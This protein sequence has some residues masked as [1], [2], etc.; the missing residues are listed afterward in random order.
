M[1][2]KKI[3]LPHGQTVLMLIFGLI[4]MFNNTLGQDFTTCSEIGVYGGG[5]Y[6][7]GDLNP[8]RHFVDS[9]PGFGL[10]YRYNVSTRHSV[11]ATAFYGNL[12]ADDADASDAFQQNRNLSFKSSILEL[13]IG[14]EIDLFK[15]RI[16][17]MKYPISPY[18]F[19]QFAVARINPTTEFEGN[20]V[21]L[22]PLGT[23]GQG[24]SENEKNVYSLNQ[25]TIPL[26]IGL[27][28]NLR[29][30]VAISVEY[31]IRKTF[32]DYIDDVSGSYANADIL[33]A[34]NGPL[35]ATLA[36]RSLNGETTINRGNP[37][38]K[39]WYTFYGVMLTI[40]PFEKGICERMPGR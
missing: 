30:R 20:D 2:G 31:G 14:Y 5:S 4:G 13:A 33:R 18:F 38:T 7:I 22:R 6:Y 24:T 40:K 16:N 26:G 25:I 39:D 17:D 8:N 27:K 29:K 1:I 21:A 12:R 9:K 10:I 37:S 32:T 28:V 35:S 19:Y 36:N 15:Y 23:E 3:I 11:R 34:E